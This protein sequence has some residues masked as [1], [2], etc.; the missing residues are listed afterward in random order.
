MLVDVQ[1]RH[2]CSIKLTYYYRRVSRGKR[3]YE[4]CKHCY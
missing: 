2:Q 3:I 1:K 4:N